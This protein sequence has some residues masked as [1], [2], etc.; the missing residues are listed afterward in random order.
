MRVRA[1]VVLL[2]ALVLGSAYAIWT[3]VRAE[4]TAPERPRRPALALGARVDFRLKDI[5]GA[6]RT[7]SQWKGE[8]A[9]VLYFWTTDC[10]CV[11]QIQSRVHDVMLK[12]P[13]KSGVKFVGIDS[14]PE[15]DAKT[16]I[17]KMGDLRADYYMLLDPAQEAAELLGANE[18][19]TFVVLDAD[20][21]LRYRGALD[22]DLEKPTKPLLVPAIEAVLAGKTPDPAESKPYG[23]PFPGYSGECPLQ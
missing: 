7:L 3:Q 10:P 22:D 21:R 16:V 12:F 1:D 8:K 6:E 11:D 18:A 13:E 9:T 2:V 5:G 17:A 14:N 23:C 15:D 19:T 20:R 4:P